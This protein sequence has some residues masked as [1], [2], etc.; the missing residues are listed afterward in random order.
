MKERRKIMVK[1]TLVVTAVMV[2]LG[3]V[4]LFSQW[5]AAPVPPTSEEMVADC[6]WCNPP[7]DCDPGCGCS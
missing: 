3:V 4:G 5:L 6:P 1:K 7:P 2:K